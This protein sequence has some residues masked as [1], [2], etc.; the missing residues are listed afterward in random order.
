[1]E[2]QCYRYIFILF[3]LHVGRF[4]GQWRSSQARYIFSLIGLNQEEIRLAVDT[5]SQA[6]LP[7]HLDAISRCWNEALTTA[8][9]AERV[10]LVAFL[11]QLH[12]HF[13]SWKG[14]KPSSALHRF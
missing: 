9:I 2:A 7:A 3:H 4:Q 12:P 5:W 11:I 13:P 10:K 1:M 8:P 14:M 6:L